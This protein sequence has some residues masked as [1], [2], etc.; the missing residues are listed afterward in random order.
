MAS[1]IEGYNYDIF[2]SY[3][4]KDNK[5]DGWVTEFVEN[6]KRELEATFKEEVSVYFDINPHDGL[7][8]THDVDA[9]LKE[10][11]KCLVCI[12]IISRTYCDPKS[13][14][15]EHEFKAFVDQASLDQFGLKV[16]LHSGNVA[17]RVLPIRI[18][19]LNVED[20]KLFEST[21]GG[22]LRSV[23]FVYKETG[24]N[25]QLRSKDDDI[26]KNPGQVLYR[27]QINKVA[28]AVKDIIES[29]KNPV[30]PGQVKEE[31]ILTE[32]DDP[33]ERKTIPEEKKHNIPIPT[34]SFVGREKEMKEVRD[35]LDNNRLITLTGA[36]G[37]GKTRLACEVATT[38]VEEYYDGVWFVDL[39]PVTDPNSVVNKIAEVLNIKELPNQPVINTLIE[40][41]KNKS[42][43]VLLDN[44]EHLVQP[45]AE[46][47]NN[48]LHSVQGIRMMATS[49]EALNVQGEVVWRIPSLSFPD[50]ESIKYTEI[51][52][53]Y[54]A[55]NLFVARAELSKP[56]FT[57]NPKNVSSVAQICSRV[58]GIPLAIEL[59]ATRIRHIGPEVIMERLED[60][61][62]ILTSSGKATPDRQQTLK[63]AID[64]SYDLLSE[65]EQLLFTRLSVF[66]GDFSLEAVEEVCSDEKLKKEDILSLLSQLVDK[67]LTIADR[68]ED[69]SVRYRFLEPLRL[70]S[71]Q[72]LIKNGEENNIRKKHLDYYLKMAERAYD[73]QF[74][75]LGSWIVKLQKEHN[76]LLSALDWADNNS[77][78]EFMGLTGA[79]AWFWKAQYFYI[80]GTGYLEKSLAKKKDRTRALARTLIGLAIITH[81]RLVMQKEY[82]LFIENL[83]LESL[84][85][86]RELEDLIGQSIVLSELGYFEFN[87]RRTIET[88]LVHCEEGLQLAIKTGK[89]GLIVNTSSYV[90]QGLVDL[91][92]T[93]RAK[94]LAEQMLK[95]AEELN[96]PVG[97]LGGYHYLG[98]CALFK[99]QFKEAEKIYSTAINKALQLPGVMVNIYD[100][101]CICMSL[102]GQGRY[103]KTIRLHAAFREQCNKLGITMPEP[104]ELGVQVWRDH[105]IKY[106][107][108][109][110]EKLPKELVT[111]YSE[112][113]RNMGF[114]AAVEYALDLE[115]D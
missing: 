1:I 112:E 33:V 72:K 9:S 79:L 62:K 105:A 37:C 28:L 90:C 104:D 86:F 44:C 109:T 113:G 55:I 53:K 67:S 51:A 74:D 4:Q 77:P 106:I 68:Q 12:P 2:I 36:G 38:L 111:K 95:T 115:K 34:T 24:V 99:G 26:I 7:L 15:W 50:P 23:D 91:N 22:V 82:E 13:F 89:K 20:I 88:G 73:E 97:I 29:L 60:Q 64:W 87:R 85:I 16:T 21:I 83:F 84:K 61:F 92:R 65:E 76:N 8:E 41:T 42:L 56:G 96:H 46:I 54:E 70:Y 100:I 49:R 48:L 31:G 25:R 107:S 10:K 18:H 45:C 102:A 94:I 35:L 17:N 78:E 63:A 108:A 58:E 30:P 47:A 43:L 71:L 103:P 75:F 5:Y 80:L 81:W 3:R 114:D 98:D 110:Y 66:A 32:V 39:A 57:L 40:K 19:D 27:D 11:L 101:Y 14:A 69:E 6:L 52:G 93:D 59:A